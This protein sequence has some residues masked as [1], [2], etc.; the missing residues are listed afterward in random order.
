VL[1]VVDPRDE[2]PMPSQ[3]IFSNSSSELTQICPEY[4]G[5]FY[6]SQ[7]GLKR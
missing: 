7:N 5:G 6:L 3:G 4:I 1:R 2:V